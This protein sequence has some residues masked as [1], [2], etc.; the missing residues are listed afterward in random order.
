[1]TRRGANTSVGV[2]GGN[3]DVAAVVVSGGNSEYSAGESTDAGYHPGDQWDEH[4]SEGR[5]GTSTMAP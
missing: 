1:V 3:I 2:S 5:S 4:L